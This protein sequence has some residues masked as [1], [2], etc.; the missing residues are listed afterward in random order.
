MSWRESLA[1]ISKNPVVAGLISPLIRSRADLMGAQ[2]MTFGGARKHYEIFGWPLAPDYQWYKNLYSRGG[3]SKR[4]VMAYPQACWM[5]PPAVTEDDKDPEDTEE[6]EFEEAWKEFAKQRKVF[7][8]LERVDRMA[9]LGSFSVLYIGYNDGA[10]Y[11]ALSGPVQAVRG[12]TPAEK[13]LYLQPYSEESAKVSRWV[14]DPKDP[15]FGLPL[16]YDITIQTPLLGGNERGFSKTVS[17]HHSR[18]LHV[19]EDVLEADTEG[20]SCLEPILNYLLDLEKVLGSS[21]EAFYQQTP[22]GTVFN[23]DK[24]ADLSADDTQMQELIDDFIHGY[25]RWLHTKGINI[26]TITGQ[27]GDPTKVSGPILELIAGTTGIP[28]RILVGSE[29]GELSS[30]QDE[31]NWNKRVEERQKNWCEPFVLVPLI[32]DLIRLGVLPSPGEGYSVVWPSHQSFGPQILAD[33]SDKK[34]GA[35]Q[36]YVSAMGADEI[37][38]PDIFLE[39][40][41]GL[42][43]E[44]I[45]RI[46]ETRQEIWDKDLEQM[47]KDEEEIAEQEGRA[48][49]AKADASGVPL[50][51]PKPPGGGGFPPE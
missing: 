49:K 42:D 32:E 20:V 31:T 48:A 41:M 27:I 36:K 39:E 26:E 23:V 33:I 12:A 17:V 11:D 43:P 38:P 3:I 5:N 19:A 35:L 16:M 9:R 21:A 44:V 10:D 14:S 2:G 7:H 1:N 47:L 46:K 13:V 15:R 25:K 37:I 6:T 28:K 18:V 30:E 40:I 22:P 8:Y 45:D 24:D 51:P 29:R 50:N 4:I 34:A